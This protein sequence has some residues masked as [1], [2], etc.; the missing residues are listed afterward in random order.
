MTSVIIRLILNV[1]L[2]YSRQRKTDEDHRVKLKLSF[3]NKWSMR[4]GRILK[5]T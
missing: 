4:P 3:R 1:P 2:R 5:K